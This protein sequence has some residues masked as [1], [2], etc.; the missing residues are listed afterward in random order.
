M[1]TP[2]FQF[3]SRPWIGMLRANKRSRTSPSGEPP[4]TVEE[5]HVRARGHDSRL[6]GKDAPARSVHDRRHLG[7]LYPLSDRHFV[8]DG[9]HLVHRSCFL[10]PATCRSAAAGRFPDHPGQRD[11]ARRKPRNHGLVGGAAAGTAASADTRHRA[12]DLDEL[13]RVDR[14]HD[15][16]RPQPQHRCRGQ[17]HPWRDQ[18][19]E[20]STA[21]ESAVAPNLSQGQPSR[22][23][24]HAVCRRPRTRCR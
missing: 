16:V 15:P 8:A 18:R 19:R 21:Q 24:D 17:R 7:T 14:G 11:A 3:A 10:P 2:A 20:R 6:L 12:N 5:T 13:A 4:G 23:A 22:L 9:R 1:M